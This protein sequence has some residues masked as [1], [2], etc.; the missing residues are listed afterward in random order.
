M[1]KLSSI[2]LILFVVA[3]YAQE[4]TFK[5]QGEQEDYWAEELFRNE[6]VEQ[7]FDNFKGVIS[8]KGKRTL[9]FENKTLEV[10]TTNP[11]LMDIF[12]RGI[13]CPQLIIGNEESNPSK[14]KTEIAQLSDKEKFKYWI[15]K[16]DT[17][18]ISNF[19]ELEFMNKSPQKKKFRFWNHSSGLANPQVYLLEL[20]NNKAS[21]DTDLKTFIQE[22][23][24]TFL[25]AGWIII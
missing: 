23:K 5:N 1:K 10:W 3:V 25:K 15:S 4:R 16:N 20:T 19:E 17:L 14:S 18:Q 7:S 12:I 2:F 22:A 8:I 21:K 9:T 11:E 6:Y 13:F 24:L